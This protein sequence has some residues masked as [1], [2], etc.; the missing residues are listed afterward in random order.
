MKKNNNF[1][2][3]IIIT[4]LVIAI[5]IYFSRK[6]ENFG[7]TSPGTLVQLASSHVPTKED[8]DYYTKVYPKVVRKEIT[9]MTGGDPGEIEIYPWG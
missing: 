4:L 7:S 6:S 3:I 2:I 1:K 9:D 8:L 5:A